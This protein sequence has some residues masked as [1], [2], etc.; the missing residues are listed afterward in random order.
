GVAVEDGRHLVQVV[1]DA[2]QVRDG[3]ERRLAADADDEV[4]GPLARRAAGAVGDR[5]EGRLQLLQ[6]EEVAEQLLR[7]P[8]GLGRE[9]LEAEGG[10]VVAEDVPDMHDRGP[11]GPWPSTVP[12][13]DCAEIAAACQDQSAANYSRLSV[14]QVTFGLPRVSKVRGRSSPGGPP[15]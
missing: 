1:A 6:A 10:G 5:D 8:P 2:G 13:R 11:S 12:R 7:R 15:Q 4:V 14:R 9:E 3:G